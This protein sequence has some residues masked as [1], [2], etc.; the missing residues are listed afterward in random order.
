[1]CVRTGNLASSVINWV[2]PWYCVVVSEQRI[3][4]ILP[5]VICFFQGLSHASPREHG[6]SSKKSGNSRK[7]KAA[8]FEQGKEGRHTLIY[9]YAK[10]RTLIYMHMCDRPQGQNTVDLRMAHYISNHLCSDAGSSPRH[11]KEKKKKEERRKSNNT[12]KPKK[13]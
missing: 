8:L 9:I 13:D 10:L 7:K 12:E 4:S 2:Q 3:W 1:M 5:V 11:P 6:N